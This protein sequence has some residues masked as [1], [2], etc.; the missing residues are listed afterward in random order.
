MT[1][2]PSS[3]QYFIHCIFLTHCSFVL[4]ATLAIGGQNGKIN[5][6][7]RLNCNSIHALNYD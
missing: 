5:T 7:P 3:V 4:L 6:L 2:Y 1:V